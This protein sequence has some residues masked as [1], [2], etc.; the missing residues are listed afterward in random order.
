MSLLNTMVMTQ[1]LITLFSAWLLVGNLMSAAHV[2]LE[3]IFM[4]CFVFAVDAMELCFFA[5]LNTNV[6]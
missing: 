4:F 2:T 3:V 5:T 1:N 6:T